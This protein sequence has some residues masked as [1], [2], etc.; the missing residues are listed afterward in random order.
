MHLLAASS[1]IN[2]YETLLFNQGLIQSDHCALVTTEQLI[3]AGRL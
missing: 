3:Y 1:E 2:S